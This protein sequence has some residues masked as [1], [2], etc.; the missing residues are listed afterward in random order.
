M[1]LVVR[2]IGVSLFLFMNGIIYKATNRYNGYIY[3]GQTRTT[4]ARR[5]QQHFRDAKSDS[6]L[7]HLA[8][9]QYGKEG[10]EWETLD[11]FSGTKEEVI[12]ALNV[13]EE[14]H[15]LKN[16]S[17][18]GDK[19]YN[20]TQGGYSSDKF[21]DVI[22]RRAQANYGGKAILQY[23][24]D[25]NF[26]REFES[27]AEVRRTFGVNDHKGKHFLGKTWRGYQWREKC[28]NLFPRKISRHQEYKQYKQQ[29][30]CYTA[31]GEFYKC[32]WSISEANR[33]LGAHHTVR[34]FADKIELNSSF[35]SNYILLRY[36]DNA[37]K[38]ITVIKKEK[39]PTVIS[40]P[41]EE[42][43]RRILQYTTEGEFMAEY[44]SVTD[45]NKKTGVSRRTISKSCRKPLPFVVNHSTHN[46]WRYKEGDIA[47]K[48]EV[49]SFENKYP[50]K[51][52]EKQER[53][54]IQYDSN[55]N[56]IKVWKNVYS[57]ECETGCSG[58]LIRRCL[59]GVIQA[60]DRYI[61][62][63]YQD[64]YPDSI[65]VQSI[66]WKASRKNSTYNTQKVVQTDSD[67]NILKVWDNMYQASLQTG[68]SHN[69][70]R[71]QCMGIPTKKKTPSIWKYYT[72]S[73]VAI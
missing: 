17:M 60:G 48:V 32:F 7:F 42:T 27:I 15:I 40:T 51:K 1:L 30:L 21:A 36:I 55:G 71:K 12:H 67:G 5:V 8:L 11:E 22:K 56:F 45:A 41:K 35:K 33:E 38:Q 43:N 53:R 4:L 58:T 63:R 3:I 69:L 16:K 47:E 52:A 28:N 57:A 61:W 37:P 50:K 2:G 72:D 14:Y 18:L 44:Y 23:D 29:V 31:K 13:A 49:I 20:A 39:K 19:G 70:I 46:I 59:S 65:P 68:E 73:Q 54:V 24:L 25:G 34:I 62:K 26:I 64:N 66:K 10:F 6:N 9:L